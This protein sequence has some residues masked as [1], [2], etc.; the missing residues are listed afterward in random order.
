MSLPR[1]MHGGFPVPVSG[2]ATGHQEKTKISC[3][4][5]KRLFQT[6]RTFKDG[7]QKVKRGLIAGRC[8]RQEGRL[9][10]AGV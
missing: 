4:V 5:L 8:G 2:S 10:G 7:H 6:S 3:V 1:G 9:K